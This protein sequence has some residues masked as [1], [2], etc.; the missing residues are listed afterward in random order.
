VPEDEE[1]DE[2]EE[3]DEADLDSSLRWKDNMTALADRAVKLGRR[4]NLMALVYGVGNNKSKE[5]TEQQQQQQSKQHGNGD[6]IFT[7]KNKGAA[8]H[9]PIQNIDSLK[10]LLRSDHYFDAAEDWSD[11]E[12]RDSI[13]HRFITGGPA[14]SAATA[15]A[16]VKAINEEEDEDDGDFEDLETGVKHEAVASTKGTTTTADGHVIHQTDAADE[17]DPEELLRKKIALK[18]KFMEQFDAES[19]KESS[20]GGGK[21]QSYYDSMKEEIDVQLKKNRAEFE[22]ESEETR[23]LYEGFRPGT[24][25]RLVFEGVPCE[26]VESFDPRVPVLLGGLLPGEDTLGFVQVRIKKHRWSKKTLKNNDPLVFSVG[27]RRFQAMPLF[28]LKDDGQR[29]RMIKYTPDHMHCF[30]TF[31]GPITPP[32]T[33]FCAFSS[34][35][36]NMPHFR[37]SAT[38]VVLELD[39]SFTLVKKLKLTGVPIQIYKN[40]AFIK[41]MFT[42]GLEVA[43]FEGAAIRTVSGIRGQVKKALPKPEGAFR[44]TFEDKILMSG[45][46][47]FFFFPKQ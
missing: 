10:A 14:P 28:S 19:G 3:D 38:G 4:V 22:G 27:W 5:E 11:D 12:V 21:D 39:K 18:Q 1:E 29:N 8:F 9:D 34:L 6:D 7:I 32:N 40:T 17:V 15:A 42:S 36:A 26:F 33:G 16:A 24:Y 41:N 46:F 37:V 2:D 13:R 45:T 20:S 44:A 25:V 23:V 47:F 35:A 31:Y 30:A 43:K